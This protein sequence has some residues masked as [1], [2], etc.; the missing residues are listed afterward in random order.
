LIGCSVLS[1]NILSVL[2]PLCFFVVLDRMFIPYEQEK[3]E[4][5]F[6]KEHLEYRRKVRRWL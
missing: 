2:S 6:G 3:M 5:T 4:S 1:G